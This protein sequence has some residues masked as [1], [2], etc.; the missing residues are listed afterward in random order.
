[1]AIG[2][3]IE[4][5]PDIA[6]KPC[7]KSGNGG[8]TPPHH[9]LPPIDPVSGLRLLFG[10]GCDKWVDCFTCVF[11]ECTCDIKYSNING[12]KNNGGNGHGT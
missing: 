7:Y 2:F 8:R 11:P 4:R 6:F 12:P 5:I 1:M 9:K 3:H 10:N